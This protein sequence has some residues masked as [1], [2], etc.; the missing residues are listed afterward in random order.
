MMRQ[1]VTA[2]GPKSVLAGVLVGSAALALGALFIP[3]AVAGQGPGMYRL[4]LH[5]PEEAGAFYVSAWAEG[6][7]FAGHDA[8]DKK[9]V[10]YTRRGDEHDGCSWL[11]TEKLTP[12]SARVYAYSYAETILSCTPDAVPYRKTPRT[13]IVTL[14]KW[15]GAGHLTA[16]NAIQA[17][18]DPADGVA[19]NDGDYDVDHDV[20]EDVA[21]S[22]AE[23]Q[24]DIA[25]AQADLEE[26]MRDARQAIEEAQ[27]QLDEDHHDTSD[28]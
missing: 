28:D 15:D 13:G 18:G 27:A 17:P 21:A 6:E 26:A 12:I 16:L 24:A 22:L 19:D 3:H 23:A 4:V 10:T 14:E 2:L 20:D 9:S 1:A 7:V 8:S 5:A 25:A 11:G